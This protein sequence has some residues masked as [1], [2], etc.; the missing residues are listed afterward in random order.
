MLAYD[1]NCQYG[2]HLVD[3]FRKSFPGLVGVVERLVLLVGK[4]HLRGH[5]DDCQY[6]FSLNYT[7]CCARTAG[8]ALE[9]SWAEA[10]QAGASTKEMNPGHRHDTITDYQNHWNITKL[11]GLRACSQVLASYFV[12]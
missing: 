5:K 2:I 8:E 9:G 4:M 6:R 11:R 10:K 12:F 7:D 1:I 3:R